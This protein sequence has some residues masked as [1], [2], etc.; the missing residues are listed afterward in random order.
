MRNSGDRV[1][2]RESSVPNPDPDPPDSHV[3]GPPL[4]RGMNPD[5]D[6][7]HQAKLVKKNLGSYCFVTSF[8][9]FIFEK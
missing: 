4:V 9:L 2:K 1:I 8:G 5:P 7:C 6:P 3:F